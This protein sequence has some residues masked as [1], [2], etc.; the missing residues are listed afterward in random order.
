MSRCRSCD[1]ILSDFENTR[2]YSVSGEYVELCDK[3]L[4]TIP[5][6]PP[7]VVRHDLAKTEELIILEDDFN[8]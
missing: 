4:S 6:F 5:D 7:T 1:S 8:E 3:C 2:K